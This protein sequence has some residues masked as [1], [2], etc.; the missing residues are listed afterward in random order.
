MLLAGERDAKFAAIARSMA[1]G[2]PGAR[3]RLVASAGHAPHLEAPDEYLAALLD[4]F[5]P[6]EGTRP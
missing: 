1:R 2:I 4:Q 6:R 5:M 3:L